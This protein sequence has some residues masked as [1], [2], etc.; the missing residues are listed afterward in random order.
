LRAAIRFVAILPVFLMGSFTPEFFLSA[1]SIVLIDVLLGGDNAVVIAMVVKSL[2]H[3][4]RRIGISAGAGGAVV[5]RIIF[6]FFA[7]RLLQVSFIKFFGGL[8]I[9]W[10]AV[11]LL[12]DAAEDPA[13]KPGA[14]SLWRAMWLILVADLT[15]SIDNI[16]A[17]AA[18][19]K[20]NIVLLIFGLGL[21]IPFVIFTSSLLSRLMDRFPIVVYLGAAILGRVG[22]D[23]MIT[24]PWV[25]GLLHPSHAWEIGVQVFFTIAVVVAG[26]LLAPRVPA[27]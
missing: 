26:K 4:Q 27:P 20:G 13:S 8:L 15:M 14:Q 10:I 2:P 25:A 24:D 22:G 11:R 7:A 3:K 21:S 12:S 19:S 17:V 6:T 5:L 16:L 23:M 1:L 18:A 9:L